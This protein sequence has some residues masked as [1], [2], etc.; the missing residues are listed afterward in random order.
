[1]SSETKH[2]VQQRVDHTAQVLAAAF[3]DDPVMGWIFPNDEARPKHLL[4]F[5]TMAAHRS[6]QVGHAYELTQGDGAALW[7]P[8]DVHFYDDA[9]GMEFYEIASAANG[10]RVDM[11]LAGLSQMAEYH[12]DEP[13]FYLANVGV[14]PSSQGQGLGR[15]LVDRVTATCDAEGVVAYLESSN[16]RNVSLYERAGF[17]VTGE[18]HL[19]EGPIMRPMVRRP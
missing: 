19:P 13:H 6:V 8:P 10:D 5:M 7:C 1:M 14:A 18:I 17:E 15:L 12:P 9:V 2:V 11:V 4:A 16:P 3:A